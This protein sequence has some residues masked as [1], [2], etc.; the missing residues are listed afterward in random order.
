MGWTCIEAAYSNFGQAAD[1]G[2]G[3]APF[4]NVLKLQNRATGISH[5]GIPG[6]HAT[7]DSRR[8]FPGNSV[9]NLREFDRIVNFKQKV[10]KFKL[11]QM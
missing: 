3:H 4:S 5:S 2:T 8:E 10:T 1:L 6:I 9:G 7:L 11:N